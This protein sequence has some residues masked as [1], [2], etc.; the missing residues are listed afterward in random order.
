[1]NA[2]RMGANNSGFNINRNTKNKTSG[3][4]R[5]LPNPITKQMTNVM[6]QSFPRD[7][8]VCIMAIETRIKN[9][10]TFFLR[11]LQ[12]ILFSLILNVFNIPQDR[13][14]IIVNPTPH[15]FNFLFHAAFPSGCMA[16]S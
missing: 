10:P 5:C 13:D 9:F 4:S 6:I 15:W 1:M 11:K 2:P 7:A 16:I 3:M 14:V 8:E 12:A